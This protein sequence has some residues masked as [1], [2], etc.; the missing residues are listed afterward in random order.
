M[1]ET[2]GAK[3][4]RHFCAK[5]KSRIVAKLLISVSRRR[6]NI[7]YGG[8]IIPVRE[9]LG[10]GVKAPATLRSSSRKDAGRLKHQPGGLKP[11]HDVPAAAT[12]RHSRHPKFNAERMRVR[13]DDI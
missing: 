2:T 10:I 3:I 8:L 7:A 6:Q 1:I 13:T 11:F 12:S 4:D 5:P 9:T